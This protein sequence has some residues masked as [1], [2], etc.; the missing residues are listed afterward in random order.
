MNKLTYLCLITLC[1]NTLT[2]ANPFSKNIKEDFT[3]NEV[4]RVRIDFTMPNGYIKH[5]LL[6][7]TPDNTATDGVDY[8]YDALEMNNYPDDLNWIIE[9]QNYIIQGVG[10]FDNL[11]QYPLGMF[12]SNAGD[13]AISLDALENFDTDIDVYLFDA[14]NNSY[15]LLNEIDFEEYVYEGTHLDR[16][17]IAF[18]NNTDGSINNSISAQLSINENIAQD[19]SISFLNELKEIYITSNQEISKLEVYN[20]LGKRIL[21]KENLNTKILRLPTNFT[22]Q[23]F[24]IVRVYTNK[25]NTS[26]KLLFY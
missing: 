25:G 10:A 24:G 2:I 5:L 7:F 19:T 21:L 9:D 20:L 15:T 26:K 14:L 11:K 12:I 4:Q 8:G 18:N 22:T 17:Y 6:A 23:N 13:I 1:Y 16:Y 3:F